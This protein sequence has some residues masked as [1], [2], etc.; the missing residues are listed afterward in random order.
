MNVAIGDSIVPI[1]VT[2]YV[3]GQ[4]VVRVMGNV[5]N[6]R[7]V[8]GV[9]IVTQNVTYQIGVCAT[10]RMVVACRVMQDIG[11]CLVTRNVT[12][13]VTIAL[14]IVVVA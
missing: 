14:W 12:Q 5:I 7:K 10:R 2:L 13:I 4:D 8:S 11:D 1:T 3:T 9:I 6:A